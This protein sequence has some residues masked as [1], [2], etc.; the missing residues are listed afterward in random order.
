MTIKEA[1]KKDPNIETELLLAHVLKKPKEFVFLNPGFSL[2]AHKQISLSAL[3]ARRQKGEP[4]AYLLGYKDFYGLRFKVNK[5]TLIPRPET[6]TLV[7][8]AIEKLKDLKIKKATLLDIGTGS[9]AIIISLAKA[10]RAQNLGL[11]AE[12]EG[13]RLKFYGADI[14]KNALNI[15]KFNSVK[16]KAKV[17]F[18]KSDLLENINFDF[19]ILV[20]NLPYGWKE[21]KN[22]SSAETKSLKFEPK[23]ALFTKEKGL[24]L[25]RKLLNQV[26]AKIHK[27]QV[28][29]FEFDPR[30][31]NELAKLI[32]RHLPMADVIFHRDMF[33]RFRVA[34][35]NLK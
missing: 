17:R 31:K 29:F 14:S 13:V 27:P 23:Q 12:G 5:H 7:N 33:G 15:S 25:Y 4:I 3:V 22:D 19:N 16:H 21:W 9:G 20:A 10:L 11:R 8:L 26:A 28:M 30:Q 34:E 1:L 18:V 2:S 32:E 35:I 6:E 24:Y